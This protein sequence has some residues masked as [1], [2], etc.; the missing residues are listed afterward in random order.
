MSPREAAW[1]TRAALVIARVHVRAQFLD[2]V[3]DRREHAAG[4]MTMRVAGEAFA[5]ADAGGREQRRTRGTAV[6]IGGKPETSRVSRRPTSPTS[7]RSG[8]LIVGIAGSAPYDTNSFI[9][10]TSAP[11]AARQKDVAPASS[12]PD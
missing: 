4:R 9:A 8:G 10:S 3:P 11:Y 12:T 5:I 2:Q 7:G 6:G 1:W